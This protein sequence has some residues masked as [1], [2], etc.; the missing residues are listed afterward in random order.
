MVRFVLDVTQN[1]TPVCDT[2][3]GD[4]TNRNA[5]LRNVTWPDRGGAIAR[6]N[7]RRAGWHGL[8]VIP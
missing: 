3:F 8:C 7:Q 2:P 1:D 4:V 6:R 5:T